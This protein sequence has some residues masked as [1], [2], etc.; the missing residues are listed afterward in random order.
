M[1]QLTFLLALLTTTCF[2]QVDSN[3]IKEQAELTAK[4]LLNDDY[5][6]VIRFTYPKVIEL[7]GGRDKMISLIKK[8]K[9]E[10][11]QQGISFDKVTI[12]NPSKTVIAGDEIHCLVPQT[13]YMKVPKGKMKSETHLIAVS[14]DNGANWFFID[15]VKL[16]KDN[17]KIVLPNYNFD[18]ILPAKK[19]PIF[20]AD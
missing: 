16:N 12:G 4:A 14:Q 6:T 5:E 2:G 11:G 18:L 7:V 15:T 3:V 1:R 19:Q 8:G 13:V 20:I 9:I 17:I 10:M